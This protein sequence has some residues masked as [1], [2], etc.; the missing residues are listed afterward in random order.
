VIKAVKRHGAGKDGRAGEAGTAS[1]RHRKRRL[2]R[3]PGRVILG[4]AALTLAFGI[5]G[6]FAGGA[7]DPGVTSTTILVGGTTPLSGSA[8][9]FA[10]VAKGANAYFRYVNS[11]GGVHGRKINYKF[12]DDAYNPAETVRKTRQLVQEDKVFA[13][14][15]SLGTEHNLAIRPYLNEVEVPHLFAATGATTMGR[16]H[17]QYPWT[18][19]YQPT[20]VS[21]GAM[22]GAYVRRT[23]PNARI[24]I[25]FQDDDYGKDL[26]RGLQRGLG[27]RANRIV[28]R[29]GHAATDD[30]V[31]SQVAKLKASRA[32][33]LMLFTTPKFTIQAFQ[34]V[35]NLGWKPQVY[36]NAV[37]SASNI[38]IISSSRGANKRVE[39]AISIVFLKDP[40]DPKWARDPGIKLYRQ[41]MRR[42]G[43]G[44]PRDVY[45][46]Y[47][48]SVAFTFVDALRKAGRNP[49]RRGVL[50]AVTRLNETNNPFVLPRMV[51]RTGGND[52]Y[53]LDQA[54]LQRWSK[55]RWVS[56][57]GLL[58]ARSQ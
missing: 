19:A 58:K 23:K 51:V 33:V 7:A 16:D 8:Q 1:R 2:G 14:F 31:Q 25:L 15:N 6:A 18:I 29:E 49:T 13:I 32:N 24:A 35:N 44:N 46:V 17:R 39:G 41:I 57:G 5:P 9:A 47:G 20:Y 42:F 26:I 48:M 56:F 4:F 27:P 45:N 11:R 50:N 37:S 53:P 36:V 43:S 34:Y 28:A 55:G 54:R 3:M 12:V 52:R 10:S 21:E 40:N 30:N 22:Y 38:M